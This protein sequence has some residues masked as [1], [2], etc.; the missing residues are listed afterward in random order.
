MEKRKVYFLS[1]NY[2]QRL[3]L[4]STLNFG[5][6]TIQLSKQ[7]KFDHLAISV[8]G[9]DDVDTMRQWD[10]H[11]RVNLFI[12]PSK[13]LYPHPNPSLCHPSRWRLCSFAARFHVGPWQVMHIGAR[14]TTRPHLAKWHLGQTTAMGLQFHGFI[15]GA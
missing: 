14:M 12:F 9:L 6:L 3:I 15:G 5:F 10:S 2:S 7:L 11:V 4:I 8:H 1:S 13:F